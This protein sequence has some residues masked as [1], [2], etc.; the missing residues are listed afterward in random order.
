VDPSSERTT[1]DAGGRLLYFA[2]AAKQPLASHCALVG[3]VAQ[4][5]LETHHPRRADWAVGALLSGFL[6]DIGKLDPAFQEQLA[7]GGPPDSPFGAG[8]RIHEMSWA[9]THLAFD[10]AKM[11]CKLPSTLPWPV[12][13]YVVYWRQHTPI[14]SW[15]TK[16]FASLSQVCRKAGAWMTSYQEPLTQLLEEIKALAGAPVF[17]VEADA[18]VTGEVQTPAFDRTA[19]LGHLG[20]S[21]TEAQRALDKSMCAAIRSAMLFADRMI[22][23][24]GP[25]E[26]H[27]WLHAWHVHKRLPDL[28][29]TVQEV[30]DYTTIPGDQFFNQRGL[31]I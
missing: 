30:D 28:V 18:R 17:E 23:T 24:M 31:Q 9:L 2:N 7:A 5:H 20:A 16:R 3:L 26:V 14:N 13:Q 11:R 1:G 27:D 15:E 10:P 22:S 8:P 6:H 19:D 29:H 4:K 25:G 12:I 21:M